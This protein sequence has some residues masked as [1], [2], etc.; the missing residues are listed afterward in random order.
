VSRDVVIYL[1][2]MA[3]AVRRVLAYTRGMDRAALFADLRTIDAVVRNLEVLGEAAK[4]VPDEIRVRY[5]EIEWK[6]I[7]GLRDVLAHEYFAVDDDIVW[8]VVMNKLPALLPRIE[9]CLLAERS[10]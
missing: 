10:A 7:S 4:H 2:D 8:D 1:E 9:E 6:K 5:R 3:E